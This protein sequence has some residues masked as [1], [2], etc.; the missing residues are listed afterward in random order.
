M[1][2]K[3]IK[4][5][6]KLWPLHC[7]QDFKQI[8]SSDLVFHSNNLYLKLNKILLAITHIQT[9]SGYHQDKYSDRVSWILKFT[10]KLHE[11]TL[12]NKASIVYT[13]NFNGLI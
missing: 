3:F 2:I 13:R 5:K 10:T 6:V 8:W 4:I 7:M 1:L 12:K 9:S 11:D